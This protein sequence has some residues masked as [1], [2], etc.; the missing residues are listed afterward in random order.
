MPVPPQHRPFWEAFLATRPDAEEARFY[1]S[2]AFG[3]SERMAEELAQLVLAG[4]KRATAGAVWACEANGQRPP[5]PGDLSIVTDWAGHPL[6]VIETLHTETV[7]FREVSAEFAA[8]EGE[9]D[10]SLEYWRE[11]HRA[12]FSWECARAGRTFSEEMLVVCE[13]FRV[14]FGPESTSSAT[15]DP[16]DT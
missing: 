15:R 3:D 4:I 10:G 11:G 6:C 12:F 8:V 16:G 13:R 1:E 14:V 5:A 7:P 9:G 2:F